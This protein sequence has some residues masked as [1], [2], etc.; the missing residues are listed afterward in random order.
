MF[1]TVS[2]VVL[3]LMFF[4][5]MYATP[6]QTPAKAPA[7]VSTDVAKLPTVSADKLTEYKQASTEAA[8]LEAQFNLAQTQMQLAQKTYE[9][10]V[11]KLQDQY[12]NVSA[13]TNDERTKLLNELKL[14]AVKYDIDPATGQVV[15]RPKADGK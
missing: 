7:T 6:V 12:K 13:R 1:K 14:D 8:L 4:T 3:T 5:T 2:T 10:T 15:E 9:E 11:K